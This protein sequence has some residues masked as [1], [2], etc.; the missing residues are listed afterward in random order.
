[1]KDFLGPIFRSLRLLSPRDSRIYFSL[2]GARVVTNLL[3]LVGIAGVGLFGSM[4][5]GGLKNE[6][7]VSFGPLHLSLVDSR[8]YLWVLVGV[9]AVFLGKSVIGVLLLRANG[10]FLARIESTASNSLAS[11]FFGSDLSR[12]KRYSESRIHYVVTNS[13]A[14]AFGDLL[15]NFNV[16]ITEASLFIFVFVGFAIAD[17]QTALL[18]TLYFSMIIGAF[19]FLI[20]RR[21]RNIGKSFE[22]TSQNLVD[23]VIDLVRAYRELVVVSKLDNYLDRLA[24]ARRLSAR[25]RARMRFYEGSP[26]FMVE[27]ALMLGVLAMVSW[28]YFRGNLSD[29]LVITAVFFAGGLRMMGALLPLQNAL[30]WI[31]I[32]GPQAHEAQVISE[33]LK[34]TQDSESSLGSGNIVEDMLVQERDLGASGLALSL[35]VVDLGFTFPDSDRE[36]LSQVSFRIREG[37]NVAII[38][39]SGAGKTTLVDLILGLLSPVTGSISV[40]GMSPIAYRQN[41]PGRVAYVPQKPGMVRGSVAQNI[42]LGEDRENIS[43]ERVREAL[44]SV[45]M[46]EEVLARGGIDAPIGSQADAFS[47]GQLQ[48]LG[49]AR[50]LYQRPGLLVLDEATS[51]LDAKSE[52][53]IVRYLETLRGVVTVVVIA[54]R[55]S[56][57]QEMDTVL[58]LDNGRVIGEGSFSSLRK[59]VPL[60]AEFVRLMSFNE[61][62]Q[63]LDG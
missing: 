8:I 5:A 43:E 7:R 52:N 53:E 57:V 59:R 16:L 41:F 19:Q 46:W 2:I 30:S 56:T 39:P 55:L 4:L 35:E 34:Q 58:A 28:Q 36:V 10:L 21:L 32:N 45:G 13:S 15:V 62:I 23:Y 12:V 26:R 33:E 1:M 40:D 63:D 3:D 48:R 51:A 49:L 47:G 11:Y 61:N 24:S 37:T 9:V 29:G 25:T 20:G 42:A 6:D 44:E 27:S 60:V 50:A 14:M 54:H 17:W 18:V 22:Q 31:R 38:G